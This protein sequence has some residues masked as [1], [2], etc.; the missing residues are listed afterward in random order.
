LTP[1]MRCDAVNTAIV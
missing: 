1:A